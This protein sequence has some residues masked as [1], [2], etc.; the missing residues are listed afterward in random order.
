MLAVCP[1]HGEEPAKPEKPAEASGPDKAAALDAV[2]AGISE[3][4]KSGEKIVVWVAVFREVEKTELAGA[5]AKALQ[6]KVQ[7]N[8]IPLAWE[9]LTPEQIADVAKQCVQGN[10]QRALALTDFCIASGLT[11]KADEALSLAAQLDQ[12]L[13][14]AFTDRMA[15]LQEQRSATQAKAASAVREAM[16]TKTEAPAATRPH[17]NG[18]PRTPT[19]AQPARNGPL[20]MAWPGDLKP[21]Q[22]PAA[23]RT[24]PNKT[25]ASAL[26]KA[27]LDWC[28]TKGL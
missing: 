5:D 3:A 18:S 21:D 25:E 9:K 11:A 7:G 27:L 10:A 23:Y 4:A 16:A 26:K 2:K 19:P 28:K 17:T 1:L 20:E 6:V 8:T 13:G 14:S 12:N 15:R 22:L 24:P